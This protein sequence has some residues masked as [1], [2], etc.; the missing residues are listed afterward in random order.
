MRQPK[1]KLSANDNTPLR[2]RR[3]FPV[4]TPRRLQKPRSSAISSTPTNVIV[5]HDR[6]QLVSWCV[7]IL[8]GFLAAVAF[9]QNISMSSLVWPSVILAL[10]LI[11]TTTRAQTHSRRRNI[12][13]LMLI[14]AV[15]ILTAGTLSHNGFTLIGV[16]LALLVSIFALLIGWTL[17]SRPAVMLSAIAA[18]GYLA[19]L[20]PD[21]GLLT[22]IADE[23][24]QIG[25]GLIPAL[26][27]GQAFLSQR[28][29]S[30]LITALTILAAGV[31]VLAVAKDLPL[32]ALAGLGFA[33]AAAHYCVGRAWEANNMF[34]ARVHS[35]IAIIAALT[36]ALYIQSLWM[37]FDSDKAQPIWT[38]NT[39]W[40]GAVGLSAFVITISSLIRFKSSQ[41][42]LPGIFIISLGVM[43]LPLATARPD[44]IETAFYQV[45]GLEARPGLGLIIGA[46]IIACCLFSIANGLKTGRLLNVLIGTVAMGIEAIILYQP[47]QFNMDF[48]VIF[49]MSLICALCIGGLIAGSTEGQTESTSTYA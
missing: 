18:I 30:H 49:I 12:S 27:I 3:D 15:T 1:F 7:L 20:F 43:L 34:G 10:M 46:S 48:G 14:A 38:A 31:W 36:A 6:K 32:P 13:S 11:W 26:L 21:L 44:L 8:G 5:E 39:F 19:S 35:A 4:P 37:Q 9:W 24:S 45:P 16:E 47:D 41:I 23:R 40:W 29:R 22:G 25:I 33:L 28:L 17:E 42:S 2:Q